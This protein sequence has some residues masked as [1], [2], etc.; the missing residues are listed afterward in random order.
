MSESRTGRTGTNQPGNMAMSD[1]HFGQNQGGST[2]RT[3]SSETD[4][5]QNHQTSLKSETDRTNPESEK[6]TNEFINSIYQSLTG[7]QT[8]KTK[9][10]QKARHFKSRK[11][12]ITNLSSF[13]QNKIRRGPYQHH[14]ENIQP[15]S[16]KIIS[17][18]IRN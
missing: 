17:C 3:E 10:K 11:T 5:Q 4:L 15:Q 8:T 18:L 9:G 6:Y 14:Q 1:R 12:T 16:Y 2:R 13:N 7:T